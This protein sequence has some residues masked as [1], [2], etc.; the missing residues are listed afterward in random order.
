MT[1]R[2]SQNNGI[3]AGVRFSEDTHN[4]LACYVYNNGVP[5]PIPITEFHSTL[6]FSRKYLPDF[7]PYCKSIPPYHGTP[8]G[9]DIWKTCSDDGPVTN[10][11]ILKYD[12]P[13]LIER[14]QRLMK[15]HDA[16]FDHDEF[17]PHITLSYN[18]GD[19][20]MSTL[21]DI[22]VDIPILVITTEYG[23]ELN[24]NWALEHK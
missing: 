6:L 17:I 3:H 1:Q 24:L 7:T 9:F 21:S 5:N 2:E 14:H 23:Q 22:T 15:Q 18:I 10:C 8:V 19:F 16:S 20:D 4:A 12:C 13:Q 11:L